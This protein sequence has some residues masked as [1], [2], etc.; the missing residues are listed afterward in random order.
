[1]TEIP[2]PD[3]LDSLVLIDGGLLNRLRSHLRDEGTT[4]LSELTDEFESV[5]QDDLDHAL[6]QLIRR[7]EV[8]ILTVGD[9]TVVR[10]E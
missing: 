8:S 5:S 1:V 10:A 3:D 9:S 4:R 7:R 6:M 2:V